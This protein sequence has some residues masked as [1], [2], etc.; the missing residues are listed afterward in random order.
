MQHLHS[1][2]VHGKVSVGNIK[3]RA[4]STTVLNNVSEAA[5]RKWTC[6]PRVPFGSHEK[7]RHGKTT[8]ISHKAAN[9]CRSEVRACQEIG[10]TIGRMDFWNCKKKKKKKKENYDSQLSG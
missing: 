2:H 3:N 5:Q 10:E 8:E 7:T 6:E 1:F 9:L 4:S